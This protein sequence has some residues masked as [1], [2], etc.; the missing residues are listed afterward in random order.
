MLNGFMKGKGEE[1]GMRFKGYG[2]V[3]YKGVRYT[4]LY[5]KYIW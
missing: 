1:G 3:G 2:A 5:I 4:Y